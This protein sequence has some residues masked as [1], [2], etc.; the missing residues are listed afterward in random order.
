MVEFSTDVLRAASVVDHQIGSLVAGA[1]GPV[2]VVG[3]VLALPGSSPARYTSV[4]AA[5]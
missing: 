3:P 5:R 4:R 1:D 2:G